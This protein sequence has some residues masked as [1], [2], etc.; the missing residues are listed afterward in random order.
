MSD[1]A[2]KDP[3]PASNLEKPFEDWVSGDERMTGAQASYLKA[4]S[5]QAHDPAS[6]DPGLTKAGRRAAL[7][8]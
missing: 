4:L 1:N 5:G 6:F 8:S 2:K 7:P 3:G